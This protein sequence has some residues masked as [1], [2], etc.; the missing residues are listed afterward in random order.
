MDTPPLPGSESRPE[1]EA[2][3]KWGV[4]RAGRSP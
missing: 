3:E 1:D 4:G 2:K